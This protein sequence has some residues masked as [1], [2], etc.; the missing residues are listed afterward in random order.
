[1]VSR[2]GTKNA[3]GIVRFHTMSPSTRSVEMERGRRTLVAR[4]YR[5]SLIM[6]T[7]SLRD[8]IYALD[9]SERTPAMR[10]FQDRL[11]QYDDIFFGSGGVFGQA[12]E[13]VSSPNQV[14]K[15]IEECLADL[16]ADVKHSRGVDGESMAPG[17]LDCSG[18]VDTNRPVL[19]TPKNFKRTKRITKPKKVTRAM[20]ELNLGENATAT[21]TNQV[22]TEPSALS[23]TVVVV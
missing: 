22:S 8:C 21:N 3:R 23:P 6:K 14:I 1:M 10:I 16:R 18:N 15:Y 17:N 4:R 20:K 2:N 13:N 9:E 12:C 19:K 5:D 7:L 11:S